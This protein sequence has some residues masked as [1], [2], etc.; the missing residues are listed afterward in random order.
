ML[1]SGFD[2]AQKLTQSLKVLLLL[3]EKKLAKSAKTSANN[4]EGNFLLAHRFSKQEIADYI[5]LSGDENIIHQVQNPIVPGLCMIYFLQRMLHRHFL[6]W[7]IAF[8]APVYAG[9][10]VAFIHKDN[11][12]LAYVANEL[13]FRLKIL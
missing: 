4:I 9:E 3:P 6:H 13:V 2:E 7:Q 10:E 1:V 12:I 11:F 8:V 5:L